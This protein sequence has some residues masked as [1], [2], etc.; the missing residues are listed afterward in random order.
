MS[1][2]DPFVVLGVDRSTPLAEIKKA[3][4]A[5]AR[6]HHPDANRDDPDAAE[7]F[8]QIS[9]AFKLIGT[10]ERLTAFREDER[11]RANLAGAF[12]ST[13]TRLP[14]R[15]ADVQT[16]LELSFEQA[17][18]GEHV[19]LDIP[20]RI[21]CGTCGGSGAA[22]GTKARSCPLCGGTGQHTIGRLAQTCA[23]CNGQGVLVDRPCPDC[24]GGTQE[25]SRQ[26]AL[27]VPAGVRD[28]AR[29]RI[30]G[31][32]N[33]GLDSA[34]DLVVSI[35]VIASEL[36]EPMGVLDLVLDVPISYAE[37]VLGKEISIP[38]PDKWMKLRIPAGS[39]SGRM[40]R[41][42]DRGL[43]GLDGAGQPVRGH[44]YARLQI[45]VPA[46]ASGEQRKLIRRLSATDDPAIRSH[47]REDR[48]KSSPAPPGARPEGGLQPP[49]PPSPSPAPQAPSAPST[50]P[51]KPTRPATRPAAARGSG[52]VPTT[53]PAPR[54]TSTLDLG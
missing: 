24:N 14:A 2:P 47:F 20:L 41:I 22:V 10:E 11:R 21:P 15:G 1:R 52:R 9:W 54:A 16:T 19:Q 28:G 13:Q 38:T 34:G 7:R 40:L 4:R 33:P 43:T 51:A 29:L 31:K 27:K 44:L 45:V 17:Y 32:G 53:P 3:Y 18:R 30:K 49:S 50:P 39:S 48:S 37:A 42:R 5:L 46:D 12:G 35:R 25:G 26:H 6:A 8:Q 36:F 23:G